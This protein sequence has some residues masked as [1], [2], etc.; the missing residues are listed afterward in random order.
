VSFY[1]QFPAFGLF[2]LSSSPVNRCAPGSS[3]IGLA[4]S[5]VLMTPPA[6]FTTVPYCEVFT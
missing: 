5:L 4:F 2:L 1:W 3:P 6:I